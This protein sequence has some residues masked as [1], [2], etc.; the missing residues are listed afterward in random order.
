MIVRAFSAND[1]LI[2]IY[3]KDIGNLVLNSYI[4]TDLT[5]QNIDP[6]L[7]A[8]IVQYTKEGVTNMR[9]MKQLLKLFVKNDLLSEQNLP[10]SN[11]QRFYSN[12][13][14]IRIQ[15]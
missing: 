6:W 5:A 15:Y 3:F 9:E 13:A 14:I 4:Q 11:N 2:T 12:S 10:D 1:D 8:K 7:S